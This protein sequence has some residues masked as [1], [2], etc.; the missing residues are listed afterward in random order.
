[1]IRSDLQRNPVGE[2]D[3]MHYLSDF[4]VPGS[5]WA[6][7]Y[8]AQPYGNFKYE[9]YPMMV[10]MIATLADGAQVLD[11]GAGTG[12]LAAEF[13]RTHPGRRLAFTLLDNSSA[14]LAIAARKLAGLG[15]TPPARM[16]H[17]SSFTGQGLDGIGRFHLIASN[18]TP[19]PTD[20]RA[21][22]AYYRRMAEHLE[23]GGAILVQQ[24]FLLD[25]GGSIYGQ[26][27]FMRFLAITCPQLLENPMISASEAPVQASAKEAAKR[28]HQEAMAAATAAGDMIAEPQAGWGFTTVQAHLDALQDQGLIATTIW[29]KRN[30]AVILA[31]FPEGK[32]F[33]A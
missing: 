29:R 12:H 28:R 16:I 4:D 21:L 9:V 24:P 17:R 32:S 3:A 33:G 20:P 1:V 15:C 31:V 18:N 13:V 10:A 22:V 2:T 26:H 11:I 30:F 6:D 25:Q 27:P 8:E 5:G 23:P 7:H 14:M 19:Y